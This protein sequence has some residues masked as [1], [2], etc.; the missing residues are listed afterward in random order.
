MFDLHK[1][2]QELPTLHLISKLYVQWLPVKTATEHTV[3]QQVIVS[4]PVKYVK[5]YILNHTENN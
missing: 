5:R 2:G 1:K 4:Y 3:R